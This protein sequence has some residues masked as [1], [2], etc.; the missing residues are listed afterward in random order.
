MDMYFDP[1]RQAI[2]ATSG[3]FL[4]SPSANRKFVAGEKSRI[5]SSTTM[6]LIAAIFFLLAALAI[7][8]FGGA[9][10]RTDEA[11]RSGT[12]TKAMI[13]DGYVSKGSK[14][15]TSYY[16]DYEFK[17]NGQVYRKHILIGSTLY[18]RVLIGDTVTI[19][20][21]PSDPK[22]SVLSGDDQDDTDRNENIGIMV[23][24]VPICLIIG[25]YCLWV[26]GKNRRISRGQ[27]LPGQILRAEGKRGSKGSYTV[28]IDF[29]FTNPYG[30]QLIKKQS[31]NR[32]DL[33]NTP[34]PAVGTPVA[35]LYVDDNFFRLM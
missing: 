12:V 6:L 17:L 25:A 24:S 15:S 30:Q 16:I 26:D 11:E 28:S 10:L 3:L 18:N 34:L 32:P 22:V 14:G 23:I 7:Y 9:V 35:V 33:R 31:K 27:L 29:G 5:G 19:K 4:L 21:L 2:A 8:L 1:Q 20:Y 13:V